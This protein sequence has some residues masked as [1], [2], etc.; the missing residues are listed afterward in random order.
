[1]N[2]YPAKYK[3]ESVD[4]ISE[5]FSNNEAYNNE[6]GKYFGVTQSDVLAFWSHH[7]DQM[8]EHHPEKQHGILS[9]VIV[10]RQTTEVAKVLLL[11]DLSMLPKVDESMISKEC[12]KWL[13]FYKQLVTTKKQEEHRFGDT[14]CGYLIAINEEKIYIIFLHFCFFNCHIVK[15]QTV[16]Y[17]TRTQNCHPKNK[18]ILQNMKNSYISNIMYAMAKD[19]NDVKPIYYY[20]HMIV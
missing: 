12:Q 5:A 18:N 10:D 15:L 17:T 14:I 6:P 19:E 9:Y 3:R 16:F 2:H 4:L 11:C 20:D 7:L 13:S 8:L 1:M